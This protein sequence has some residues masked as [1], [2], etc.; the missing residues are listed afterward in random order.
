MTDQETAKTLLDKA[1]RKLAGYEIDLLEKVVNGDELE[2]M[3][4][5]WFRTMQTELAE[6]LR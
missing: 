2:K 5:L 4:T 6:Y 1:S 3:E